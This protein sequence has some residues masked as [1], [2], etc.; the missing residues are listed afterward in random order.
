M[1][2]A[3]QGDNS[4]QELFLGTLTVNAV[5]DSSTD[6]FETID[7]NGHDVNFKLDT[8]PDVNILPEQL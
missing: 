3:D 4:E 1:L 5:E 6:W 2:G 8:G 7:V